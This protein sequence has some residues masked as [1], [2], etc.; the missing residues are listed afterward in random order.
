MLKLN[1][2]SGMDRKEGFVNIDIIEKFN[3][4]MIFDVSKPL[5]YNAESVDEIYC[6]D[7][8]EH[9][10][11]Y[12]AQFAFKNWVSKLKKNGKITVI[13]PNIEAIISGLKGE[14][15]VSLLFGEVMFMGINTGNFGT[16]KWGYAEES[17]RKLFEENGLIIEK[18]CPID[19]TN[20]LCIG[21]K[22]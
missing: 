3:P 15:L 21:N 7:I 22:R 8:L 5:P 11:K 13:V 14:T 6:K 19:G 16:H 1:L 17:L 10:N 20:L 4:D 12:D 2:G 9:L 18:L